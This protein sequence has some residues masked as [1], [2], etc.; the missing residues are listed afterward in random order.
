MNNQV[1]VADIKEALK[2]DE[3]RRAL[4]S[5]LQ[6]DVQKF[7]SNPNCSCNM[8]IYQRI[9]QEAETNVKAYFPNKSIVS[10][11]QV[12]ETVM[13]NNW[14]VINCHINNLEEELKKLKTGRK[15]ISMGRYEDKVTVI[16]NELEVVY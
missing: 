11:Q 8:K 14:I 12:M 4:P 9:L 16:V 10:T 6:D 7:L 5:N 15:Q 2:N 1:T 3:F 13:Q